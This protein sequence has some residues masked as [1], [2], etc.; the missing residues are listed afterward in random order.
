MLN[1]NYPNK[2]RRNQII[3]LATPIILGMLSINILD[4][5]DTAMIG[6]LGNKALAATGFASFLFF[7]SFAAT[8]GIAGSVQTMTARRLGEESQDK[9]GLPLNA[10]IIIVGC[11]SIICGIFMAITA[12]S[13][14]SLFSSDTKV[15]QLALDYYMWRLP[16]VL[17]IGLA[18]CFRGFWNGIKAP[19]T[20]T[21]ILIATHILNILLNWIFIFGHFGCPALGVKG[22]AIGSTLS[23]YV[24]MIAYIVVTKNKKS[25]M[26]ILRCRPKWSEIKALLHLGTPAAVDQFL[27]SLFLL[28]MFWIF[29][30]IGTQA[31]AVAHVVII[32]TLLLFLPGVGLGITSL[33][34][35]SEALGKEN[36]KDAKQWA[37]D[38]IKFGI[39]IISLIGFILF[40][41]PRPIL[42]LFIENKATLNMAIIPFRLDLVMMGSMCIGIIFLESLL[43][44]GATRFI[45][46]LKLMF[47]YGLLLPGSYILVIFF[48]HGINTVWLFWG[49]INFI[50]TLILMRVWQRE[51]WTNI[52][53]W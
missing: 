16:G 37:W 49:F 13:I 4:I 38:I 14:L 50:E 33:S 43:G 22:A 45:L 24:G 32:C 53:I 18:L 20:Y 5:V 48:G 8:T 7:V 19:N 26:N 12:P 6:Q 40:C 52:K 36:T 31:A 15:V 44:A 35:V 46:L 39:P 3:K 23:L 47:R 10:G 1:I 27:F 51:R 42:S 34:L 2:E 41:F 25:A 30:Q 11:Y 9:C 21:I 29:G 28:G 17:A